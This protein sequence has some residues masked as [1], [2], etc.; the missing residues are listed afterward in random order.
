MTDRQTE[1]GERA[2]ACV[3]VWEIQTDR[4]TDRDNRPD[5][6][7][8]RDTHTHPKKYKKNCGGT[9]SPNVRLEMRD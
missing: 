3:C 5:R 4:Q 2:R 9:I 7:T 8:N 6:Q 1:S